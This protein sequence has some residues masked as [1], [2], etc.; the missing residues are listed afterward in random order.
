[1]QA[2]LLSALIF[3]LPNLIGN[4]FGNSGQIPESLSNEYLRQ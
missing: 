1:M 2:T 4:I 3:T